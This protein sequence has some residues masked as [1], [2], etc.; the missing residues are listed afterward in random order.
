MDF[1]S[2]AGRCSGWYHQPIGLTPAQ[3]TNTKKD[4]KWQSE[5]LSMNLACF[6]LGEFGSKRQAATNPSFRPIA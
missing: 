6:F 4:S 2:R 3:R 5:G 1:V